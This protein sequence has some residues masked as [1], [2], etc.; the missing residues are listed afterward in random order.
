M[1]TR[2]PVLVGA[3]RRIEIDV[4]ERARALVPSLLARSAETTRNRR[5]ADETIEDFRRAGLFRVLQ[6]AR[7]GGFELD[8]A[9]FARITK[10][11]AHGCASSAWVY[12]VVEELFWVIATFPEDS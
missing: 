8:F 11:L 5:V 9:V 12:A 4:V 6:P 2:G 3:D 10:E 1:V 7:F